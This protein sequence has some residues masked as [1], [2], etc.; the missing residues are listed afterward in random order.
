P[1]QS[2]VGANLREE[3]LI[4]HGGCGRFRCKRRRHRLEERRYGLVAREIIFHQI[5]H[6]GPSCQ[7]RSY[8]ADRPPTDFRRSPRTP[9]PRAARLPRATL[10][11]TLS[12][13]TAPIPRSGSAARHRGRRSYI[14]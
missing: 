11:T 7:A 6:G 9:P 3:F 2:L 8:A 14:C 4:P 5:T 10:R 12:S 1:Q 13:T